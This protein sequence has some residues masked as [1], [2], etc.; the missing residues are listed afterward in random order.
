MCPS[1]STS[2]AVCLEL[3]SR[4]N[5]GSGQYST[6][7][8]WFVGSHVKRSGQPA[9]ST[10]QVPV[11]GLVPFMSNLPMDLVSNIMV[12]VDMADAK[13]TLALTCKTCRNSVWNQKE[14]WL[15]L[16]GPCF[17]QESQQELKMIY[18]VEATRS[19]FRRWVYGITHGWSH[20][21]A[22]RA[23]DVSSGEALQDAY[24]LVSGLSRG[25]APTRDIC[26]FVDATVRAI[27]RSA[28]DEDDSLATAL[29]L[30]CQN[31]PDLLSSKQVRDLEAALDEAAERAMLR[32]VQ[33]AE[34]DAEYEDDF[35]ELAEKDALDH[36]DISKCSADGLLV[37]PSE[38][39]INSSDASWL[40]QRF[41]MVMSEHHGWD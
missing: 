34:D 15:S 2:S 35:D 26:R 7:A 20:Q 25:D 41:L 38:Q 24:F 13:N 10:N 12:F 1:Q 27:G 6:A 30:R 16:G 17:L 19:T 3:G 40:S 36:D 14:F 9:K 21:F 11:N 32:H 22:N 18:G 5:E 39:A 23:D 37:A 29:V 28:D 33:A 31:R 8:D 4:S